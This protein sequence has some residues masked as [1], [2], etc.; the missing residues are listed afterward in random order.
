M[1][2]KSPSDPHGRCVS[3]LCLFSLLLHLLL[4]WSMSTTTELSFLHL[5]FP[6]G[7]I[8]LMGLLMKQQAASAADLTTL[9]YSFVSLSILCHLNTQFHSFAV[10]AF[11]TLWLCISKS[12][13]DLRFVKLAH[14]QVE[15]WSH[16]YKVYWDQMFHL[17]S[18]LEIPENFSASL[19]SVLAVCT[20]S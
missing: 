20:L 6:S 11:Q 15:S 7:A 19:T 5:L 8:S 17:N 9:I 18:V 13:G 16:G 2:V 4:L 1:C 12:R 14:F 10:F 3:L